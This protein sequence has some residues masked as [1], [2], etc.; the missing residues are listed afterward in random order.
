MKAGAG[1]T[2]AAG[3][4]TAAA[5]TTPRGAY[6]IGGN[7]LLESAYSNSCTKGTLVN[8]EAACKEAARQVTGSD[9]GFEST[10]SNSYYPKG[11]FV[12]PDG[13]FSFNTHSTGRGHDIARP[14]CQVGGTTTAAAGSTTAAA[15]TTF[16]RS[17]IGK[18]GSYCSQGTLV[19][20]E[21]ECRAAA[22][23]GNFATTF[24]SRSYPKG[25]FVYLQASHLHGNFYF[26]THSTGKGNSQ[27]RP[28]C[29]V[30]GATAAAAGSTTAAAA[31]WKTLAKGNDCDNKNGEK[32]MTKESP[33]DKGA[34]TLA[35]C[36]EA[37]IK[38]SACKAISFYKKYEWCN[39]WST[40][41]DK[42]QWNV[43]AQ[44]EVLTRQSDD[45]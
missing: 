29:Q 31:T 5:G 4:T 38:V 37:C 21:Q 28:V 42:T 26:N 20:T 8:T 35:L 9:A 44:A 2:A 15:G 17:F 1:T 45:K 43:D 12:N 34:K 7:Y 3:A 33:K 16:P 19:K 25:C 18:A 14:V 39:L 22:G 6:L 30:G 10:F 13:R 24:T 41:C 40:S 23:S 11:C 27:A 32:L 36:R